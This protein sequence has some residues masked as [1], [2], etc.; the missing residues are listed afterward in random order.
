MLAPHPR[1]PGERLRVV[2]DANVIAAALIRPD[3]WTA[4]ELEERDDVEWFAPAFLADELREH[5]SE[6]AEKAGCTTSQ[7][8]RRVAALLR[9]VRVVPSG[10]VVGAARD[11]LVR[12]AE[13]VDADDA[14]YVA[15]LVAVE[16]D[17]LWTRDK[18]LLDALPGIAVSVVPRADAS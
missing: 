16:A 13:A 14:V 4:Q 2:V 12:K 10:D 11:P 9:R 3:G 6:Y 7:W 18:G 17:L 1:R 5:A 15:T 8:N